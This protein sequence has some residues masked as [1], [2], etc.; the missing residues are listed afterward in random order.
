[1]AE[2]LRCNAVVPIGL[3]AASAMAWRAAGRLRVTII[4]KATFT[5]MPDAEMSLGAPEN[6]LR[7]DAH[8]SGDPQRS[9]RAASDM[10]PYMPRAELLFTGD[11]HAPGDVAVRT[12][13]ARLD[14]QGAPRPGRGR[15]R[16]NAHCL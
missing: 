14:R 4:A 7:G 13:T 9:V 5:L 1:M 11:A 10:M 8:Y 3:L 12:L 16:S 6:V 15:L 2:G